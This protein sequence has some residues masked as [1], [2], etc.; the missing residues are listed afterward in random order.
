MGQL[1][2]STCRWALIFR[3]WAH[4]WAGSPRI[5]RWI[6]T[7]RALAQ[8]RDYASI[9][10]FDDRPSARARAAQFS[11][12]LLVA[13]AGNE[14]RREARR[15]YAIEVLPCGGCGTARRPRQRCSPSALH[16]LA[17][18][19]APFSL[20]R[21]ALAAPG[22]LPFI[23]PSAVGSCTSRTV[24]AWRSPHA[25]GIV[26]LRAERAIEAD[27]RGLMWP[28]W[29]LSFAARLRDRPKD[30]AYLGCGRRPGY[31]PA[32]MKR[33]CAPGWVGLDD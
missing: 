19:V 9:F 28:H 14:S 2:S 12:A 11:S 33:W 10:P 23:L 16:I 13:A 29:M 24:R 7:S 18:G 26:A 20:I 5:A 1:T 22:A 27:G 32:K 31:R 4:Y 25:P 30:A 17:L 3:G 15:D 21:R 6:A 8:Y